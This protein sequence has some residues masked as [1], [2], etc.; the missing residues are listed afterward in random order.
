MQVASSI[1]VLNPQHVVNILNGLMEVLIEGLAEIAINQDILLVLAL[2]D[3]VPLIVRVVQGQGGEEV[4]VV[5]ALDVQGE[6]E[7]GD[8]KLPCHLNN[9]NVTI[10][11]LYLLIF[12]ARVINLGLRCF[13]KN[14]RTPCEISTIVG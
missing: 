9:R 7:P 4:E 2:M 10:I 1:H 8:L 6:E 11:L 13:Q 5:D 3:L 12:H 14:G